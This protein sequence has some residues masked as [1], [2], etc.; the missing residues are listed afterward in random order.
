MTKQNNLP[1]G[2]R[3]Q[4]VVVLCGGLRKT[5]NGYSP[6]TFEDSDEFGMLGAAIRITAAEELFWQGMSQRFLFSTG[7]SEKQIAKFGPAV[8]PESYVYR[9][10]F[11]AAIKDDPRGQQHRLELPEVFVEDASVNTVAN[12]LETIELCRR[13][14]WNHVAIISSQYHI[15]RI[16]ALYELLAEHHDLSLRPE[17][18]EAEPIVRAAQS[19]VYDDTIAAAYKSAIAA[20][21]IA[22]EERGLE[23][24]RSGKYT[25]SEYQ[26]KG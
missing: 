1:V 4:V 23:H 19:G 5:A 13:Y 7:I 6:T 14:S 16:K 3:Y 17:F 2:M 9:E 24:I 20:T 12:L 10:V 18:L 26:L 22:N 8:P 11:L 25:F 21:R 15:P